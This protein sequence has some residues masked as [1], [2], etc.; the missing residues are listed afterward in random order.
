MNMSWMPRRRGFAAFAL[1]AALLLGGCAYDDG[2]GYSGVSVGAGYYGGGGFYDPYYYQPG[3]YAGWYD[4]YYYPGSGYYIFDRGGR[5]YRWDDRHRSYWE[6][7]RSQWRRDHGDADGRWRRDDRP[8]RQWEG[9]RGEGRQWDGGR[10]DD[11]RGD[12]GRGGYQRR[13]DQDARPQQRPFGG[14]DSGR[15][16]EWRE[17][18]HEVAPAPREPR[19]APAPQARPSRESFGRG[20]EPS[21]RREP[22]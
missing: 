12:D 17:Q 6:G 19:A 14:G 9:R 1:G 4:G 7:R 8:N 18:R 5:R 3:Y 20:R 15:R 11:R 22:R 2:Y 10:G 13:P 21:Q 16:P